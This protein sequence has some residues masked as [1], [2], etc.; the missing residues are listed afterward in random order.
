MGTRCTRGPRWD[1]PEKEGQR[2]G[3]IRL[4]EMEEGD[5]STE[6][7][8]KKALVT[9]ETDGVGTGGTDSGGIEMKSSDAEENSRKEGSIG[10]GATESLVD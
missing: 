7:K 1:H 8:R 10:G 4:Q 9:W 2:V 6:E 3:A 5:W